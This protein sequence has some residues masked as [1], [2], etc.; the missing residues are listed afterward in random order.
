MTTDETNGTES[1][2]ETTDDRSADGIDDAVPARAVA[3]S[4]PDT[5]SPAP[6][7]PASGAGAQSTAEPQRATETHP[8]AEPA[9]RP[10]NRPEVERTGTATTTATAVP[11][12]P[13]EPNG[14][15][16]G[17]PPAS[18]TERPRPPGRG[19]FSLRRRVRLGFAVA[20]GLALLLTAAGTIA[21][22]QVLD[23][24]EA[25]VD[26]AD[27]GLQASSDMLAGL[28]DQETGVRAYVLSADDTFL[29][30][31]ERGGQVADDARSE[32][33]RLAADLP[34]V[35]AEL[36]QVD[37]SIAAWRED[38]AQPTV[39]QVGAGESAGRDEASLREGRALFDDVRSEVA[40][41]QGLL[42][43]ARTDARDRLDA[44]TTRLLIL[45]AITA[46]VVAAMAAFLW[47]L[48]RRNVETPL[49]QLSR[50]AQQIAG[51]DLG[52]LVEPVGPAELQALAAA[53]EQ[54]RQRIVDELGAVIEAR[55]AL[56]RQSGDLARSNA[57]LEQF[58]YVASHDLQEPLRKVASFCQLLQSRYGGQLDERADQY[59][60]FAVDGA[61]RMQALINDL[62]AFS[63]VGRTPGDAVDVRAGQ[64]VDQ[65]LE[66]LSA[67]ISA[68]D[69]KITVVG[70]LPRVRVEGSLGVALFQNLVSNALK[71]SRP[72]VAPRVHMS[73]R[74][75]GGFNEFEVSDEGI[76]IAP[77]YAEQIFVIFQ[78]LHGRDDYGGTGIGLALCRKIVE[79]HGGR[80]WVDTSDHAGGAS[81][82]TI[83]FTLPVVEGDA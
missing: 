31:Y 12:A 45:L 63:R 61:K 16:A 81:G 46:L 50:D 15:E 26:R 35:R 5:P 48:M 17:K 70:P 4:E 67:A 82:T 55:D 40:D 66:N 2:D 41:L 62:L 73:A 18:A 43:E 51:G 44:T 6:L 9:A 29:E 37:R 11:T 22:R 76:G 58:A 3:P 78:R 65:A 56:E 10:E 38:Y 32:L 7:E 28:V 68:S 79:G 60:G 49:Q 64:L 52:H 54:M 20:I 47:R 27:P 8:R 74:R 34:G 36:R 71:F 23:A 39:D 53:M 13:P 33:D 80:I 1:T 30:P 83:R 14:K 25:L 75:S 19:A 24:R 77:E 21:F 42:A 57:E 72:D 59:I 69:A